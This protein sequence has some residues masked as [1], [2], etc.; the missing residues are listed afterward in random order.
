MDRVEMGAGDIVTHREAAEITGQALTVMRD[1][2]VK[3]L[4][5]PVLVAEI[6]DEM[7]GHANRMLAPLGYGIGWHMP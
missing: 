6:L 3:N 7:T 5:D 1:A 4:D 2:M